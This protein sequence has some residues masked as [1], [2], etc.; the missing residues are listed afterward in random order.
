MKSFFLNNINYIVLGILIPI[1]LIKNDHWIRY[2]CYKV[3]TDILNIPLSYENEKET[4]FLVP[5][6]NVSPKRIEQA[7]KIIKKHFGYSVQ[8]RGRI[9]LRNE[10]YVAGTTILDAEKCLQELKSKSRTIYLTNQKLSIDHGMDVIWGFATVG[11][12]NALVYT[13]KNIEPT[14]VHEIGHNYGLNHCKNSHCIMATYDEGYSPKY[15][16]KF[17]GRCV[18]RLSLLTHV[19][20]K[21]N[22]LAAKI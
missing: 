3:K 7:E 18:K 6:G 21:F 16:M 1:V 15:G 4:M 12:T 22:P 5:I 14:I 8:I 19:K 17:C 10:L 13:E 9:V 2:M 20:T 11:G